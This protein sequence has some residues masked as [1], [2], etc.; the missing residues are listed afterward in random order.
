M[1]TAGGID[2]QQD[3][4][5][6][7]GHWAGYL[8]RHECGQ[9]RVGPPSPRHLGA[10]DNEQTG[11]GVYM[12]NQRDGGRAVE[13]PRARIHEHH[14]IPVLQNSRDSHVPP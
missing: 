12:L 2:P 10:T 13:Q 8:K 7:K 14:H 1:A 11:T 5:R 3:L 4:A 6:H 9:R